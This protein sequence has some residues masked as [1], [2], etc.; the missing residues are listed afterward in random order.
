MTKH[1]T[2]N[3]VAVLQPNGKWAAYDVGTH[4]FLW[5]NA[6]IDHARAL[7]IQNYGS[8]R[9]AFNEMRTPVP[10]NVVLRWYKKRWFAKQ[11]ARAERLCSHIGPIGCTHTDGLL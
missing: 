5:V 1:R 11:A 6:D 10:F 4:L 7:L 8:A 3:V 2:C 9:I